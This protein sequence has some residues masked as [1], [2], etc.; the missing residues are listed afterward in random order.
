MSRQVKIQSAVRRML[1]TRNLKRH[2]TAAKHAQRLLRGKI[3]RKERLDALDAV[4]GWVWRSIGARREG[5]SEGMGFICVLAV[6]PFP[7][8]V[9]IQS[10]VRAFTGKQRWATLL[11]A[12]VRMQAMFRGS[13]V[14]LHLKATQIAAV[15]VQRMVREHFARK[16]ARLEQ[17]AASTIRRAFRTFAA[18]RP[19]RMRSMWLG[20]FAGVDWQIG[21]YHFNS[22]L[23]SRGI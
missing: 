20:L 15:V 18:N 13:A 6:D 17:D 3:A 9:A 21:R 19:Q 11:K 23:L 12:T 14:R 1:A 16:R 5:F 22:R 8:A 10:A 2:V 4:R 7:Q